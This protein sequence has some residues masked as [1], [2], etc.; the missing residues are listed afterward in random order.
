MSGQSFFEDIFQNK[1]NKKNKKYI[2][3]NDDVDFAVFNYISWK[4]YVLNFIRNN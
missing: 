4:G 1:K 3:K 2:N